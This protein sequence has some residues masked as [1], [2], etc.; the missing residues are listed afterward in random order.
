MPRVYSWVYPSILQ[1]G[2]PHLKQGWSESKLELELDTH[3]L[4]LTALILDSR[5]IFVLSF[6]LRQMQSQQKKV[7]LGVLVR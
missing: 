5:M 6:F 1:K 3:E 7:T 2:G 4:R